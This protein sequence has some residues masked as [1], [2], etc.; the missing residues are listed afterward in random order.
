MYKNYNYH[1]HLTD[2]LVI[3][4]LHANHIR[5][6]KATNCLVGFN[7]GDKVGVPLDG[8]DFKFDPDYLCQ[9]HVIDSLS[10]KALVA[11]RPVDIS[12]LY[13]PI[14]LDRTGDNMKLPMIKDDGYKFPVQQIR[15]DQDSEIKSWRWTGSK[16]DG[17]KGRPV[18][19]EKMIHIFSATNVKIEVHKQ[20]IE[21]E[22]YHSR[23]QFHKFVIPCG[24]INVR[25]KIVGNEFLFKAI[26]TTGEITERH[27][28]V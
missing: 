21:L 1:G 16:K 12:F 17:S 20:T 10:I 24:E 26:V 8:F 15:I 5:F 11:K 28:P 6:L 18:V 3:P 27:K 19:S 23:F 9:N 14:I 7:G 2:S 25:P 22:N 13:S 4:D